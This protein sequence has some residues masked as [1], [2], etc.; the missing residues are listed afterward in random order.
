MSS[1]PNRLRAV[2]FE[3][4]N[5]RAVCEWYRPGDLYQW[6]RNFIQLEI[7][8]RDAMGDA[9]WHEMGEQVRGSS[10]DEHFRWLYYVLI[11]RAEQWLKVHLAKEKP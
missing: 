2:I 5:M 7:R 4:G 3:E 11:N 1:D 8:D 10:D 9:R 6:D